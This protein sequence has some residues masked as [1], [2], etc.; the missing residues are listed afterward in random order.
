[1][2]SLIDSSKLAL[3]VFAVGF[4]ACMPPQWVREVKRTQTGG[5]MALLAQN[6]DAQQQA[7]QLMQAR[8]PQGYAIL[9]EG[10]QVVG[11]HTS[12]TQQEQT[13]GGLTWFGRPAVQT[14]GTSNSSTRNQTEW[15]IKYQC[16][17][18]KA[19]AAAPATPPG[20]PVAS[21][22]PQSNLVVEQSTVGSVHQLTIRY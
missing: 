2:N 8:C 3:T 22:A 18:G 15:R 21:P 14:T 12:S 5:E 7:A 4:A 17:A 19:P 16:Q 6:A 10:E 9:E 13:Q 11:T 1:M 20:T